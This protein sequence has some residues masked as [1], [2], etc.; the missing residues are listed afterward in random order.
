MQIILSPEASY[1]LNYPV[2]LMS[3]RR[4]T[5]PLCFRNT[6]SPF[7]AEARGNSHTGLFW[8][9]VVVMEVSNSA[10]IS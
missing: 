9:P 7:A 1:S 5:T 8:K 2:I 6:I 4:E 10:T 3:H